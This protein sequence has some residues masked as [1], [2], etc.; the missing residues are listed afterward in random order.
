MINTLDRDSPVPLWAQLVEDLRRR[1]DGG[2]FTAA[3]PSEPRLASE[4]AISRH[5]V[6]EAL[7]R[8]RA[9]GVLVSR[10]G[11]TS[12]LAPTGFDQPL[13]ALY[14]LYR[15]I[16]STGARQRS[17][18]LDLAVVTD[19]E[20]AERLVLPGE[21]PLIL[22]RRRR[23]ADDQPLALDTAWLPASLARPLLE[24]DF[25]HTGLYDELAGRCG[26][27]VDGG[28]EVI[29]PVVPDQPIRQHLDIARSVGVFAV[30]R[31]ATSGGR[32]VECRTTLVRGDRYRFVSTWSPGGPHQIDLVTTG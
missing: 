12:R 24:A 19:P 3:F 14:S 11:Y 6:R 7:R 31:T 21:T 5:T 13:G 1:A 26:V 20:A 29:V 17:E 16:E 10:R 28:R 23:L 15:T 30:Q 2:E 18:V 32:P 27:H 4:Y 25:T 9:T 8:L 22:L